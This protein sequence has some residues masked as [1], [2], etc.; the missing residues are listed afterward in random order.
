[1]AG[2]LFLVGMMGAG[3]STVGRTLAR[4]LGREFFDTDRVLTER[5]GVPI[6]TIFEYEGESGFR[7]RE[8]QV[9]AELAAR[10]K[11]VIATGGGAV[12]DEASRALMRAS[13]TVIYLRAKLD[14]LWERTRRDAA[15][16]LL[17]TPDPRGTLAAILA[18]RDPLYGACA[19][20]VV[21]TGTQ[22]V[23]TLVSRILD[24]LRGTDEP[25]T[26]T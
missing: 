25:A 7:A 10:D 19:H 11:A 20:L 17:A 13:G 24:Q 2:N 6:A 3:K 22:S 21:D 1:M 18:D 14:D 5:T 4:R 9:V 23:P 15:R 26:G 8:R 16:P 12:L